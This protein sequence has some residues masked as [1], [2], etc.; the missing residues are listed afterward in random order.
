MK[1]LVTL[2]LLLVFVLTVSSCKEKVDFSEPTD[3]GE[4]LF[5]QIFTEEEYNNFY[6][7]KYY[8]YEACMCL[9]IYIYPIFKC[10][11]SG[12]GVVYDYFYKN[13]ETGVTATGYTKYDYNSSGS[14]D[15]T[16]KIKLLDVTYKNKK[17]K[18]HYSILGDDLEIVSSLSQ[19][20]KILYA[21]ENGKKDYDENNKS[22]IDDLVHKFCNGNSDANNFLN[23]FHNFIASE[24]TTVKK[25]TFVKYEKYFVYELDIEHI[26][27][28][29][30]KIDEYRDCII[31]CYVNA[32]TKE[33]DYSETITDDY[34]EIYKINLDYKELYEENQKYND[35]VAEYF[36]LN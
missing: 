21:E 15:Y 36:N 9:Y 18:Y 16:V 6:M 7:E 13:T 17:Y 5:E 26:R 8:D 32:E 34:T 35:M 12:N 24:K 3:L 28:G 29:V 11:G 22:I 4:K 27:I 30:S 33:I 2:L 1:K 19:N 14:S 20:N 31:K 23:F 25:V 10:L